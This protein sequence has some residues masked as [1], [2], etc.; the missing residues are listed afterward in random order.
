[1]CLQVG[2]AKD[3]AAA[4]AA[5]VASTNVKPVTP[6]EVPKRSRPSRSISTADANE[7]TRREL[8][9]QRQ[10]QREQR[11]IAREEEDY[12]KAKEYEDF[13]A[14]HPVDNMSNFGR[15]HTLMHRVQVQTEKMLREKVGWGL[16]LLSFAQ[17]R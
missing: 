6:F 15:D 12:R 3:L 8:R 17:S 13:L 11:R 1:M 4:A 2:K 14:N 7:P 10:L 16:L 5:A 9:R